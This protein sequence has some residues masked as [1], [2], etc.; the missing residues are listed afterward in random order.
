MGYDGSSLLYETLLVF[1]PLDGSMQPLLAESYEVKD[2]RIDIVLQEKARWSDGKPLTGW[3]VKYTFDI[4]NEHRSLPHGVAWTYLASV[5][6][7]EAT[8]PAN[9]PAHPRRVSFVMNERKNSLLLLDVLQQTRISPKHVIEQ[10][11]ADSQAHESLLRGA[12]YHN[13]LGVEN[14]R[15]AVEA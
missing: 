1:N 2:D 3:D 10:Q 8:D 6:L 9:P 4:A 12:V 15:K 11:S 13:G 5:D 7:P 14:G